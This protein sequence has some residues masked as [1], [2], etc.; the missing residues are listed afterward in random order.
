MVDIGKGIT[1]IINKQSFE[2]ISVQW[3]FQKWE[4]QRGDSMKIV[5]IILTVLTI[6]FAGLGLVGILPFDIANPIMLASLA[7]LLLLRSVEYKNSGD[8]GIFIL[9]C[10]SAVFV[11]A[12]VIYH[13]LIG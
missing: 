10:L 6:L 9:T 3:Q 5:Q 8:K 12:V 2:G 11:Y 1:I 7:T 13:I 4:Y